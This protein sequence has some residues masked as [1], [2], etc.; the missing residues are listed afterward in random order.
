MA[1][2]VRYVGG[3]L[4]DVTAMTGH[5]DLKLADHDSKNTFE[6]TMEVSEK[7]M[8]VIREKIESGYGNVESIDSYKD[9]VLALKKV[10]LGDTELEI[11]NKYQ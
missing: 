4:D 11:K 8:K 5:K 9:N 7:V 10:T 1:T 2:L 3:S 6:D